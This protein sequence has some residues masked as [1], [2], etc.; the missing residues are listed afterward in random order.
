MNWDRWIGNHAGEPVFYIKHLFHFRGW[1]IDLHKFVK[2]DAYECFH[3]HPAYALRIILWGGYLEEIYEEDDWNGYKRW[4]P[5]MFGMVRPEFTH[6]LE[7]ILKG[8]SYSLWVRAPRCADIELVGGGW[9]GIEA[10]K[11]SRET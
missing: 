5:G 10:Q 1:R 9:G 4:A 11:G 8:V 3:T 6:R 7:S 2:A